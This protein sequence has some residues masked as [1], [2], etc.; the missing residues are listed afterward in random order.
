MKEGLTF[1]VLAEY[2]PVIDP[3]CRVGGKKVEMNVLVKYPQQELKRY[4]SFA[5]LD[6]VKMK[7]LG[8]YSLEKYNTLLFQVI[9]LQEISTEG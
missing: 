6:D 1:G 2:A 3:F 4:E 9:R 8:Q 5:A 7:P